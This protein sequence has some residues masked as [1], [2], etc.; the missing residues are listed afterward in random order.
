MWLVRYSF[1]CN[2]ILAYVHPRPGAGAPTPF[3]SWTLLRSTHHQWPYFYSLALA[4]VRVCVRV[5]LHVPRTC[6]VCAV[7][8]SCL[9]S[10]SRL[11]AGALPPFFFRGRCRDCTAKLA[12]RLISLVA[13]PT[14]TRTRAHTPTHNVTFTLCVSVSYFRL[15]RALFVKFT[16]APRRGRSVAF[17]LSGALSPFPCL[18]PRTIRVRACVR[19]RLRCA[20]FVFSFTAIESMQLCAAKARV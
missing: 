15:L 11:G 17:F 5:R 16:S 19:M 8:L 20:P 7:G 12:S 14:G 3:Y 6:A 13:H 2:L 9:P 18:C 4:H 10:T 1:F